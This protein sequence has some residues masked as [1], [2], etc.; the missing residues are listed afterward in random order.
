[1][2]LSANPPPSTDIYDTLVIHKLFICIRGRLHVS[3]KKSWIVSAHIIRC[4]TSESKLAWLL[5]FF[6]ERIS[7]PQNTVD[8]NTKIKHEYHLHLCWPYKQLPKNN[9]NKLEI[10]QLNLQYS[11]EISIHLNILQ[12]WEISISEKFNNAG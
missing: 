5:L 9:N 8:C 7:S 2:V 11:S 6:E 1:M 4:L 10:N 12:V 3:W